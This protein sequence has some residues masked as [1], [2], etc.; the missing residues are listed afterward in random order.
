MSTTKLFL[1]EI[2]TKINISWE[3]KYHFQWRRGGGLYGFLDQYI[4][5]CPEPRAVGSEQKLILSIFSLQISDMSLQDYIAVKDKYAK[6]LP[7]SAG[8]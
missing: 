2:S 1:F 5:P 7:H 8:R 4:N 6:Y 3:G